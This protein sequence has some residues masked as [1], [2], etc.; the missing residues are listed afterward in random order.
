MGG[1]NSE[2]TI[3]WGVFSTAQHM[4]LSMQVFTPEELPLRRMETQLHQ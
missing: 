4:G 1:V 3:S 2:N